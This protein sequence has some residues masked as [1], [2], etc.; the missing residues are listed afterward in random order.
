VCQDYALSGS[1]DGL[2]W[3][4]VSDGCS[5]SK[6]TDVGARILTHIAKD[7][8]LGMLS[9][10]RFSDSRFMEDGGMESEFYDMV[11]DRASNVRTSMRL[12]YDAFDATLLTAFALRTPERNYIDWRVLAIGD[13]T[14]LVKFKEPQ[15]HFS[16][17]HMSYD[18]NAPYYLS[19]K[20]HP[21]KDA[22]YQALFKDG[23]HLMIRQTFHGPEGIK[24]TQ[25][26]NEPCREYSYVID[27]I[28]CAFD[29]PPLQIVLFSDG[30]DSYQAND[31]SPAFDNDGL[32]RRVTG[33]K[34]LAGEFVQRRMK[35]FRKECEKTGVKHYD[36]VSCAAITL[37]D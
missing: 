28:G 36:D 13:G 20:M 30:L 17:I 32:M 24:E 14:V 7:T 18:S 21:D 22:G 19:Y 35:A 34:S 1:K 10:G 9:R 2:T 3:A 4:I 23:R 12:E 6:D 31:S 37:I 15:E 27:N 8:L 29:E 5:S 11:L 33:Y 26:D 16:C 25:W